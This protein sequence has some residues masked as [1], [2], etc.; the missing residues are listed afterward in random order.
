M[1]KNPG[2]WFTAAFLMFLFAQAAQACPG[3]KEALFD[4]GQLAQK[5]STAKGYAL[6]IGMLLA[7]PFVLIAGFTLAITY[8]ARRTQKTPR[9]PS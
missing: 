3:C 5:I 6:S 8:A 7:V 1:K 9:Q 2:S 4:P